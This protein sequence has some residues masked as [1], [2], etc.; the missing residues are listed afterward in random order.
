MHDRCDLTC[1]LNSTLFN[2]IF[3]RGFAWIFQCCP[4]PFQEVSHIFLLVL[5]FSNQVLFCREMNRGGFFPSILYLPNFYPGWLLI[6]L[7][8][9]DTDPDLAL[10]VWPGS[11]PRWFLP[12]PFCGYLPVRPS[13]A[14]VMTSSGSEPAISLRCFQ[15][16]RFWAGK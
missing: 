7:P 11:E 9:S 4:L 10:T 15:W 12:E 5:Q 2:P 13:T 14:P 1:L 6:F 16:R 3:V 8:V